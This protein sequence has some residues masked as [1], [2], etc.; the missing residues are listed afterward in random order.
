MK[1]QILA[2]EEKYDTM[3]E[4]IEVLQL[5][6][7]FTKNLNIKYPDD[8]YLF[9]EKKPRQYGFKKGRFYVYKDGFIAFVPVGRKPP[10]R[11][12][13]EKLIKSVEYFDFRMKNIKSEKYYDKGIPTKIITYYR[14]GGKKSQELYKDGKKQGEWIKWDENGKVLVRKN[15]QNGIQIKNKDIK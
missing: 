13:P 5:P 12:P 1:L 2:Y 11:K 15:F 9:Y 14:V 8:K 10:E 6:L 3:P 7:S 4:N